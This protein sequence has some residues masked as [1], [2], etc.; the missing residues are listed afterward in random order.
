MAYPTFAA[1]V[2]PYD[3]IGPAQM[4]TWM[5]TFSS[6]CNFAHV[7]KWNYSLGHKPKGSICLTSYFESS[8]AVIATMIMSCNLNAI[9]ADREIVAILKDDVDELGLL[10]AAA[11]GVHWFRLGCLVPLAVALSPHWAGERGQPR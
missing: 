5:D 1:F 4:T 8:Q 6:I 7:N 2:A 10:P 11:K 3:K 9:F